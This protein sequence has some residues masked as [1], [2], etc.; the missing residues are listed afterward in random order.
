MIGKETGLMGRIRREMY[1]QN[2]RFH[3]YLITSSTNSLCSKSL[4]FMHVMKVVVSAVNCIR[5][6]GLNHRQFQYF[7]RK[8]MLYMR[9]S[10][11]IHK[12][13]V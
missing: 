9:T 3:M 7:C 12:S 1:K 2:P 8:S 13:D 4:K 5:S 10:C 11:T 6:H